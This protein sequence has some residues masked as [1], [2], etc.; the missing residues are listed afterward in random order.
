MK[1]FFTL[2]VVGLMTLSLAAPS[3]VVFAYSDDNLNSEVASEED[4]DQQV[5]PIAEPS[6]QLTGYQVEEENSQSSVDVVHAAADDAQLDPYAVSSEPEPQTG[7]TAEI[8]YRP[9][10]VISYVQTSG[11]VGKADEELV[12]I[13]NNSEADL[14]VTGW[15]VKY[16]AASQTSQV[17]KT[18]GCFHTDLGVGW[19]VVVPARSAVVFASKAL[20][21]NFVSDYRF[22]GGINN[23]AGRLAIFDSTSQIHDAVSWGG[24]FADQGSS[25]V[26]LGGHF[27]LSRLFDD[28]VGLYRDTDDNAA[29]FVAG[30]SRAYF[31]TGSLQ[32]VYDACLNLGGIDAG[33]PDG[34]YRDQLTGNC[35]DVP[36]IPINICQGIIISEI[37]ANVDDQFIE[38]HN[39][40]DK[41]VDLDGCLLQTNRNNR[42]YEI[43]DIVLE[44]YAYM[45]IAVSDTDLLLTKTTT[46]SVYLLSADESVETD[47]VT[48]KNLS[49][50]TS[51][52]LI[53]ETWQQTYLITPSELNVYQRYPACETGY[54]R[55]EETGRCNKIAEIIPLADCGE[56][57]ERNLDTG[58][59][60]NVVVGSS[61]TPC[62]EGQYRSEETNRCRS[63]VSTVASALKPCADDQFRN[64]ETNR[65]RKIA[66]SEDLTDCG[67]GRERNPETNR[68]RNVQTA[69]MPLAPF[70]TEPTIQQVQQDMLGWWMFGGVSLI[71]VG[72]AGW[73]WRFEA[74]RL[75]QQ[76]RGKLSF[77]SKQ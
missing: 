13:Y 44:P 5:V 21:D 10:L 56:G 37:A 57:R 48:Y 60:R 74:G 39:K 16:A 32:D 50:N 23:T 7:S 27:V 75:M 20:G 51:W 3:G 46:G 17:S 64:P 35:T 67:E 24:A 4:L 1:R 28:S 40:T 72:Y 61:L 76:V 30:R 34:L 73:Q 42:T 11:G 71:A 53:G 45:A 22:S 29:D 54:F 19:R 14:D 63:I 43:E 9:G 26:S 18:I 47:S 77:G 33:V 8:D 49:K 15:C 36:P 70:A 62:K 65:C 2:A 38:L 12:E 6:H 69:S 58:R 66:S 59:C 41:P 68:C 25:T 52:S 55:S 31:E